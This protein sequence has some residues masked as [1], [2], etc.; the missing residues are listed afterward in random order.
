[1][2]LLQISAFHRMVFVHALCLVLLN[3]PYCV[4]GEFNFTMGDSEEVAVTFRETVEV[5]LT[6]TYSDLLGAISLQSTD[7]SVVTL[8]NTVEITITEN[9]TFPFNTTV[10]IHGQYV[11]RG[12]V[13]I[14][15]DAKEISTRI[16]NVGPPFQELGNIATII[17]V[18]WLV[19]SYV[20][21]AAKVEPRELWERIKPPWGIIIGM[22]C[23]FILMPPVAFT[24]A[25][26]FD[27]SGASAVGLV[28]VGTCPGG[29]F[30]NI[31]VLLL[32]GDLVLSLA[33]T[34]FSTFLA[35]GMMP[36]N[37]LIY[38]QPF[39]DGD[40]RLETPFRELLIQLCG[41]VL[42]LVIGV[43]FFYKFPKARKFC[44]KLV[45]PFTFLLMV[46]G[47]VLYIPAQYYVFFGDWKVWVTSSIVTL[48][49]AFLGMAVARI[50]NFN[51]HTSIT[52]AIETGCQNTLLAVSV[53][54][55]FY[56][57]PESDVVAVIP[58]LIAIVSGIEGFVIVFFYY[59][60][61]FLTKKPTKVAPD[62][63]GQ[64]P[65]SE[66]G[67]AGDDD[68]ESREYELNSSTKD[69]KKFAD[70]FVTAEED[71]KSQPLAEA[72]TQD[73]RASPQIPKKPKQGKRNR[74][75]LVDEIL[76]D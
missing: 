59:L 20:V 22:L 21:M 44:L 5:N 75:Y 54:K 30:S 28:L 4:R 52:I 55:L 27:M 29:F 10:G 61:L 47:V 64:P 26:C 37:L 58:L 45:K 65:A 17:L 49:G 18:V 56:V 71:F 39:I 48:I 42:P 63:E 25:K 35:V 24:L 51:Y 8:T 7:T 1:M 13:R 74:G 34:T 2:L 72:R 15:Q 33:M 31:E 32:D 76:K 57:A 36:L 62:E 41:L 50:V 14:M 69:K 23:Q 53:A 16:V 68:K 73:E 70:D 67:Q 19:I 43:P 12:G 40:G 38:A 9:T 60:Y 6:V 3:Y 11:G 66:D 46:L